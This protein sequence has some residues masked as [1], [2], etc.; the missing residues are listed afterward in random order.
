MC[1]TANAR[2]G[3]DQLR[4]LPVAA[5]PLWKRS[6]TVPLLLA[7]RLTGFPAALVPPTDLEG[8]GSYKITGSRN[9]EQ[10]P[11]FPIPIAITDHRLWLSPVIWLEYCKIK[12]EQVLISSVSH[13]GSGHDERLTEHVTLNFGKVS[14]DY[15]PQDDK[16]AGGPAIPMSWDIAANTRA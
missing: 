11:A 16:G 14:V 9:G 4:G 3:Q 13:A 10:T 12:M 2:I 5:E 8:K 1:G 15:T 7:A 6:I